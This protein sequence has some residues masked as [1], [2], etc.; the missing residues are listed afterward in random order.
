MSVKREG[1][2]VSVRGIPRTAGDVSRETS[3]WSAGETNITLRFI[4]RSDCWDDNKHKQLKSVFPRHIYRILKNFQ[5]FIS[6]QIFFMV[7]LSGAQTVGSFTLI[8]LIIVNNNTQHEGT[9]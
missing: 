6:G 7:L 3:T 2:G 1:R 9:L 4:T 5:V 8:K